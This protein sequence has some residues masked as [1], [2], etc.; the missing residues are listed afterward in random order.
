M[1]RAERVW[2]VWGDGEMGRWGLRSATG[3]E[4][5]LNLQQTTIH[6]YPDLGSVEMNTGLVSKPARSHLCFQETDAKYMDFCG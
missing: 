5:T 3:V 2:E 6:Q 1:E 4:T